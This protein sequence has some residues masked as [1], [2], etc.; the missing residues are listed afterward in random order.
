LIRLV[1]ADWVKDNTTI[2]H[3]RYL[4][5]VDEHQMPLDQD[6][7]GRDPVCQHVLVYDGEEAVGTGR[8][9]KDGRIGRLAV[10]P[11]A[12]GRGYGGMLVE[13]LVAIGMEQ[14]NPEISVDAVEQ[15]V[16]FFQRFG[17]NV[18][19]ETF[20]KNGVA[21]RHMVRRLDL[22]VRPNSM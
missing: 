11:E 18:R 16:G 22:E 1:R 10:L 19:D 17:F 8:L 20:F 6:V 14:Q 5:F 13:A 15:V 4:V 7:D 3:I 2:R 9:Q 21:Y 12:R